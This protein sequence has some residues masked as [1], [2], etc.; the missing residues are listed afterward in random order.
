MLSGA[1]GGSPW[2]EDPAD[3][4]GN[5]FECALGPYTSGLLDDWRLPVGFD[6]EG[7][8]ERVAAEPDVRT[9]G[10]M[11]EDKVSGASSAGSG[12]FLRVVQVIFGLTAGGA[13]LMV[14]WVGTW[15]LVPVV[16]SVPFLADGVRL[17]VDNLGV[18][19]HVG[20]VTTPFSGIG[21]PGNR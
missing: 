15:S 17:G 7:A 6:A 18:V 16:V 12:L 8:A 4:A 1:N 19:R 20:R 5:L 13:I 11:V 9:D 21:P 2:A 10:S 14:T 3:G